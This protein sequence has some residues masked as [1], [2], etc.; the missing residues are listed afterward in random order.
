MRAAIGAVFV[1]SGALAA[2]GAEGDRRAELTASEE[3]EQRTAKGPACPEGTKP[4]VVRALAGNL[5]SGRYQRYEAPGER[6]LT[7]LAPDVAMLQEVNAPADGA[8]SAEISREVLMRRALGPSVVVHAESGGSIPNAVVSRFPITDRGVWADA[9]LGSTRNFVWAR[10]DVPGPRDWLAVSVHLSST[11]STTRLAQLEAILARVR[12]EKRASDDVVLGGDFNANV[13]NYPLVQSSGVVVTDGPVP[14]DAL[15]NA[16]TNTTRRKRIDLVLA[17]AELE[18]RATAVRI[19]DQQFPAGLVFDSRV[20]SPL[21]DV[22]PIEA[23]DSAAME[24]QH[25]PVVRDFVLCDD[26]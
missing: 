3:S 5:S 6:L 16:G 17:G 9:A 23:G 10:V 26:R 7:G 18:S 25:M 19:G 2:C 22:A 15:G 8:E 1:V 21:S 4:V 11:S 20:F 12:Q 24:M 13:T 14:V